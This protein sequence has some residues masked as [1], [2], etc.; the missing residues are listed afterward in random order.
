MKKKTL[1]VIEKKD[2]F[3]KRSDNIEISNDGD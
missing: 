2:I 3:I 1:T